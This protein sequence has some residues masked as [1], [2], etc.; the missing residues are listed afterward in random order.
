MSDKQRE[1]VDV[2]DLVAVGAEWELTIYQSPSVLKVKDAKLAG[3]LEEALRQGRPIEIC[4]DPDS[5]IVVDV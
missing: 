4:W 5:G 2:H 1:I 3:R